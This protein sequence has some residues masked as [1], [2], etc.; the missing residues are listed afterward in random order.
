MAIE[1]KARGLKVVAITSLDHSENTK[2][3]H[4]GGKKLYEISDIAIDNCGPKGD[5][6]VELEGLEQR[7]GSASV[8]TGVYILN[9]LTWIY[10]FIFIDILMLTLLSFF[11]KML[12]LNFNWW[13]MGG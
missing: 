6:I 4:S 13:G 5:S 1:A 9:N 12:G 8:L 7:T 11:G 10:Y 3:R 2:C